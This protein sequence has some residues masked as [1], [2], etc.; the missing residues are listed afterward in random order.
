MLNIYIVL[1]C[2]RVP[3]WRCSALKSKRK[4][5]MIKATITNKRRGKDSLSMMWCSYLFIWLYKYTHLHMKIWKVAIASTI[6]SAIGC[7]AI[8]WVENVRDV[9]AIWNT[10][11][12]CVSL[13]SSSLFV[14]RYCLLSPKTHY[15]GTKGNNIVFILQAK[16]NESKDANDYN[17]TTKNKS[18]K[19]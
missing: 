12:L 6:Y 19:Q 7:M 11:Y 3:S 5:I 18:R 17:R 4:K 14:S 16:K 2:K 9:Y 8:V 10:F 1:F 15:H 13:S